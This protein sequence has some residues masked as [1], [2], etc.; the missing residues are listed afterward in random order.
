VNVS[1]E[2]SAPEEINIRELFSVLWKGR[3]LVI[4]SALLCAAIAVGVSFLIRKQYTATVVVSPV[5]NTQGGALGGLSSLASQFGGLASLAGFSLGG[6]SSKQEYIAVLQ[7]EEVTQRF[8]RD[9]NLMPVLFEDLWDPVR[10]QW[11]TNDPKKRPT[12]WKASQYFKRSVRSVDTDKKS[13]LHVLTIQWTD[14]ALAAQWANGLVALTNSYLRDR[15]VRE[16]ERNIAFLKQEALQTDMVQVQTA[17][18][19]VLESEIKTVMMA[20]GSEEF[21]L[22]TIDRAVAPERPSSPK[23]I[24]WLI[25]G[26][27]FGGVTSVAYLLVRHAWAAP[28][29]P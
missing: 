17:I 14:P 3:W 23:K 6:D 18:Y 11:T 29:K 12:L 15:K 10:K 28:A 7:S 20:R 27:L 13:G 2:V 4:A 25:A 26:L 16:S 19:N 21:A 5:T 24:M 1:A 9:N 22:R 8:I